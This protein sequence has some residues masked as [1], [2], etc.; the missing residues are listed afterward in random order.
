MMKLIIISLVKKRNT[1]YLNNTHKFLIEVPKY[2]AQLYALDKK[3]RN[4]L[5]EDVIAKEMKDVSPAFSKLDNGDIVLIGYERVN[6]KMMFDDKIEDFRRKARLV[7]GG[8]V[9]EP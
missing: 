7:A 8:H 9:T 3:N 5:W 1:R 6:Y 2:V 4:T